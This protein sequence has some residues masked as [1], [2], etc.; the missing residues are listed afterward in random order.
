MTMTEHQTLKGAIA[1]SLLA[2][3]LALA[4]CGSADH[5]TATD[6]T[7]PPFTASETVPEDSTPAQT[8]PEALE[9]GQ[10]GTVTEEGVDVGTLTITKVATSRKALA[11]FGDPPENARFLFVT[12]TGTALPGQSFDLNPF[13][14]YVRTPDG[15]HLEAANGNAMFALDDGTLD[16][17]TL[18]PGEHVKGIVPFD[19]PTGRLTVVYAPQ[20]EA[21]AELAVTVK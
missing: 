6:S 17:V 12:V 3:V 14:F 21:L 5:V 11:E 16:A 10:P 1:A 19:V 8:G 13:D 9:V 4:G 18:T 2:A 15:Q 7:Q 20:L